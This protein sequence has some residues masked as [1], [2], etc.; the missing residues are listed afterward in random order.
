M[1]GPQAPIYAT[2]PTQRLG[3]MTLQDAVLC[4]AGEGDF[5]GFTLED[6]DRAFDRVVPLRWQQTV[7]LAGGAL[8]LPGPV[9]TSPC[10]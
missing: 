5:E 9:H 4:R 7:H 1:R 2:L 6:V 10:D 8:G 3:R